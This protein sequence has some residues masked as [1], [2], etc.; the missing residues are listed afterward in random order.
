M[1]L[2]TLAGV[3]EVTRQQSALRRATVTLTVQGRLRVAVI[4]A[5]Q[6]EAVSA[7]PELIARECRAFDAQLQ[8]R[9]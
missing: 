7:E 1:T 4:L 3:R 8:G 9:S 5:S 2:T 6:A